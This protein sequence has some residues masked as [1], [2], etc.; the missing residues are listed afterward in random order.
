MQF[1]CITRPEMFPSEGGDTWQRSPRRYRREMHNSAARG[2]GPARLAARDLGSPSRPAV[3]GAADAAATPQPARTAT[4]RAAA[5]PVDHED[6]D[7]NLDDLADEL[8]PGAVAAPMPWDEPWHD[9]DR[10]ALSGDAMSA[11]HDAVPADRAATTSR[12]PGRRW[13]WDEGR[14]R[15]LLVRDIVR[16]P[17]DPIVQQGWAE[18]GRIVR[19]RRLAL[20]WSQR[21]LRDASGVPQSSISRLENGRLMGLRWARFGRLVA[22]MGGLDPGAS[23]PPP[24][25]RWQWWADDEVRRRS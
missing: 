2:H 15:R 21:T 13:V 14:G 10:D 19:Q 23:H 20:G 17:A 22:S 9:V 25:R 16:R 11:D 7:A 18:I 5:V 24:P 4:P 8:T 3:A 12:L 6:V 1:V